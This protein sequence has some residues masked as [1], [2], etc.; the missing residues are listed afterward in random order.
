M[1]TCAKA[2]KMGKISKGIILAGGIGSR[3]YPATLA[4]SKQLLPVYDK[5][6]IYYPLATLMLS[7]IREILII[8]TPVDLPRF[9]GLLGD[10]ERWGLEFNYALQDHPDGIAQAL[11]IGERFIAGQ[12]V[13]LILGDNL[14]YGR[15]DFQT[16]AG[17]FNDGAV[18][19]GY[20]VSDPERYGVIEFN[21]QEQPVSIEEKP[22]RPRS[23]YALTGFYFFDA[24]A[25]M[26]ARGLKPSAR[27]E[28]EIVDVVRAYLVEGRLRA[29]KLGRGVAW[30]DTGTCDSLLAAANFIATIERRQGLKIACLEEIAYRLGYID[31][32]RIEQFVR[33]AADSAYGRYVKEI[34]AEIRRGRS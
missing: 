31:D 3:L 10:G 17:S 21:D 8:S 2:E 19:F 16:I 22:T 28:L 7:G 25:P 4:G 24:Q 27:G 32:A 13:A 33:E 1:A 12:A 20:Y 30:L 6:M 9:R 34:V 15:F 26:I 23:H 29:F 18:V 5:P 14:F 11:L